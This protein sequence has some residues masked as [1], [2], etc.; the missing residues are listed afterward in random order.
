MD[1]KYR[2]LTAFLR[3][4][5][6]AFRSAGPGAT[7]EILALAEVFDHGT[8]TNQDRQ[9]AVKILQNAEKHFRSM[10]R[11]FPNAAV[12]ILRVR[13]LQSLLNMEINYF[14]KDDT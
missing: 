9:L 4:S 3:Q 7:A 5:A 2:D 14:T 12:Q 10:E 6:S 8:P 13:V 1:A 11:A